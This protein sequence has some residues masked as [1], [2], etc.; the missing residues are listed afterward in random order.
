MID[1][2]RIAAIGSSAGAHLALLLGS[3]SVG[4]PSGVSAVIDFYGPTDL[5]VLHDRRSS[6]DRAID[7]L[8][9][10]TPAMVPSLYEEAS[11]LRH[12]APGGPPVLLVHGDADA[13]VPPDQSTA[14]AAALASVGVPNKLL[15]VSGARH[16]FGLV[17][18]GRELAPEIVDF[19]VGVWGEWRGEGSR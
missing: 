2:R 4:N 1:P 14:M 9:G 3:F 6:A 8:L 17:S 19:L 12:V 16:G 18:G 10:G 11:P 5:R 15:F 7:L 13:L